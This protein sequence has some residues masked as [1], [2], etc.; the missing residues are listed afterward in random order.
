MHARHLI[1]VEA[2]TE[3]EAIAAAEEGLEGYGHGDVWDWKEVGGRWENTLP[4]GKNVMCY[5]EDKQAFLYAVGRSLLTRRDEWLRLRNLLIGERLTASDME[6]IGFF[7]EPLDTED[8]A[9]WAERMTEENNKIAASFRRAIALDHPPCWQDA[10]A[11]GVDSM[12]GHYLYKFGKHTA[13]YYAHDSYFFDVAWG[14]PEGRDLYKR[15]GGS[16]QGRQWI[17]VMDLHN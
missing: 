14:G 3:E 13:G 7:G 12:L 15:C 6:D 10:E 5:T 8:K 11:E 2:D 4:N 17:V 16:D 9:E 1:A